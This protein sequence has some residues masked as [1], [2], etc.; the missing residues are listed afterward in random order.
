MYKYNMRDMITSQFLSYAN[1]I[2]LFNFKEICLFVCLRVCYW[3][4]ANTYGAVLFVCLLGVA[5]WLFHNG[6]ALFLKINQ[7]FLCHVLVYAPLLTRLYCS[8][9]F[10]NSNPQFE[11]KKKNGN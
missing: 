11:K 1:N 7:S 8:I 4:S 9:L 3:T 10:Q 6:N 5:L 2:L